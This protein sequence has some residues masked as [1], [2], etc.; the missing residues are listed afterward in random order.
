MKKLMLSGFLMILLVV[1]SY[2]CRK[3]PVQ[4]DLGGVRLYLPVQT[5]EYNKVNTPSGVKNVFY[6]DSTIIDNNKATIGRVL[7]YDKSLSINNSVAC[8]SCHSQ[9]NAFSDI[10]PFSRGFEEKQTLRN[11][12][13]ISNLI[14]VASIGYF[15]DARDTMIEDMVF[16]PIANHIEMGFERIDLIAEKVGN[17][18]YYRSLFQKCYGNDK[19]TAERM[20]ECLG[21]FLFSIVSYNSR[22]DAGLLNNFS[23]FTSSEK[24]GMTIF[25]DE[26]SVCHFITDDEAFF[27]GWWG[28][29]GGNTIKFANIGLDEVDADKG[30][31]GLFK[32]PGL[33]NISKTAPYMHDG[34][35]ETLEEVIDFYSG[36]IKANPNLS[37]ELGGTNGPRPI[38]LAGSARDELIAFLKTL[39]DNVLTTDKKFSSPFNP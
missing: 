11:S 29:G 19:I 25:L 15:W 2:N 34:R 6:E 32:V 16:G 3:I 18:P 20:R 24:G 30:R 37:W 5:Y 12:M 21:Q 38:W 1:I 31:N 10:V 22:F 17:L 36:G 8:A 23:D 28:G 9:K 27:K 33:R 4:P 13:G 35:K 14:E 39:D 26:C 7:F